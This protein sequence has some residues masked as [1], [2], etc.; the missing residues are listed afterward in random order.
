M[1]AEIVLPH[2]TGHAAADQTIRAIITLFETNF[3]SRI[4]SYY[5]E[6]S[7][8]D[9]TAVATSDLDMTIVLR[10]PF[11]M[12]EQVAVRQV[13]IECKQMSNIELDLTVVGEAQLRQAA[14]PM[15]KLAARLL[16]GEEIRA[17]IPLLPIAAWTQQRMHAAYWLMIN[18]FERP[19]PVRSPLAF[20][21][22]TAE[23][24][25]YTAR[26]VRLCDGTEVPSTRNLI[27]I[28]G[29]IASARIAYEGQ[30]YVV[31]KR[32]CAAT[33]RQIINDQWADLLETID[34]RCRTA[35]QYRIPA[36]KP[37]QTELRTMLTQTLAFEN[38]FLTVY[39]RFL[40]G[41]LMGSDSG[42]Q[43]AAL[44]ILDN[45]FYADP[46]VMEAVKKLQTVEDG[47]V[48]TT[49]QTLVASYHVGSDQS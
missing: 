15:F 9:Q 31:R 33:Y 29:W 40:L 43:Q 20:P 41:E 34:R 22:P 14:D 36:T 2:T 47:A 38:H 16:Y 45:T 26:T 17:N 28:T 27:R 49:A 19:K 30:Q 35:W 8:A 23:F 48:R 25:G 32:D 1:T 3:P 37:E 10:D 46:A 6:G 24:L 5:V 39:R 4:V 21:Q 44:R 7:Y 11:E 18:V 12:A 42:N 13:E